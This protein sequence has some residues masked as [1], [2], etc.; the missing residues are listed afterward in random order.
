MVYGTG[1]RKN[2]YPNISHLVGGLEHFLFSHILGISS[3][4][5]TNSYFFRGVGQ[6]PTSHSYNQIQSAHCL[7][8]K[9]HNSINHYG[10]TKC[11]RKYHWGMKQRGSA[12]GQP[13]LLRL[14]IHRDPTIIIIIPRLFPLPSGEL[15]FC[16]G[17]I[18]NFSWEKSTISTGPFSIANC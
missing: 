5:L 1:F 17:K 4:H 16:Y 10:S 9:S 3:F 14:W 12:A 15:T 6:P 7:F 18:H 8:L 11:L 2:D 13:H